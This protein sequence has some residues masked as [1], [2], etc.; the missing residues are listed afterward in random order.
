M[1]LPEEVEAELAREVGVVR[2]E[3]TRSEHQDGAEGP[4]L[5][6]RAHKVLCDLRSISSVAN[7]PYKKD[8]EE[9]LQR[10]PA[11]KNRKRRRCVVTG[12][13]YG[14]GSTRPF[15]AAMFSLFFQMA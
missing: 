8:H 14:R 2:G 5:P 9:G 6:V 11:S 12:E 3:E 15:D 1:G 10:P 4:K 13:G 7:L